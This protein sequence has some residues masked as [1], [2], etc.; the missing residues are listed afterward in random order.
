MTLKIMKTMEIM[1]TKTILIMETMVIMQIMETRMN[2]MVMRMYVQQAMMTEMVRP[3]EI[4]ACLCRDASTITLLITVK[5]VVIKMRVISN[6]SQK[7]L[8]LNLF[9]HQTSLIKVII[10]KEILKKP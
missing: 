4:D 8:D 5:Q 3:L 1:T 7:K 10:M 2:G 9:Q 6:K